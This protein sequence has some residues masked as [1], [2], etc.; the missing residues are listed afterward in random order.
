[1][2]GKKKEKEFNKPSNLSH[3]V[4]RTCPYVIFFGVVVISSLA[5][6]C[7]IPLLQRLA[8]YDP[9]HWA[10]FLTIFNTSFKIPMELIS[11]FWAAISATYVGL[12]RA[13]F[14]VDAFRNGSN[15]HAFTEE[16]IDKLK[17]IIK[18]SFFIY[19]IAA[20]MNTF[21]DAEFA[22]APL[23]A[24]FGASI[25]AYVAGNKTVTAFQKISPEDVEEK[26]LIHSK[27]PLIMDLDVEKDDIKLETLNKICE[28]LNDN[29][30]MIIK[31][32]AD[33]KIAQIKT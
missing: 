23:F 31:I 20:S 32:D 8:G 1:M 3:Y 2:K 28:L 22:L 17:Q 26:S 9:E 7:F 16:K 6:Q 19:V 18:L 4:S 30:Q 21:F 33:S 15:N 24:S 10:I 5:L 13:A 12:D 11:N 25:L 14:A 27:I 29:K